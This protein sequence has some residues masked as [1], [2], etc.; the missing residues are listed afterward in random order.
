MVAVY[1]DHLQIAEL[2]PHI[3][4]HMSQ[5]LVDHLVIRPV[6]MMR[7]TVFRQFNKVMHF[8]PNQSLIINQKQLHLL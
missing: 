8:G 3:N 5:P 7:V 2:P 4:H 6:S 1:P